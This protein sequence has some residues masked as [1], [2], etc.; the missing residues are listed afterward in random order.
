MRAFCL[1]EILQLTSSMLQRQLF[2]PFEAGLYK[3]CVPLQTLR[4]PTT[5][6]PDLDPKGQRP[7]TPNPK[8]YSQTLYK[9]KAPN[10]KQSGMCRGYAKI[11]DL[12]F[13]RFVLRKT[14]T[15]LGTPESG[16]KVGIFNVD[17]L[18]GHPSYAP[19]CVDLWEFRYK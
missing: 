11:C 3:T 16:W 1:E 18:F 12:G 2:L 14:Y 17:Q 4:P 5:Q 19:R 9:P 10:P 8:Q 15:F 6:P 13:A 7:W